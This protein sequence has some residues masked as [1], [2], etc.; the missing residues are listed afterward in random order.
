MVD[1]DILQSSQHTPVFNS[2]STW[3]AGL[4]MIFAICC[5]ELEPIMGH[6]I[7]Y[8]S[9]RDYYFNI[10]PGFFKYFVAPNASSLHDTIGKFLLF[11]VVFD[12][13]LIVVL[14][15]PFAFTAAM[16]TSSSGPLNLN[17]RIALAI[18]TLSPAT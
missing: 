17:S 6:A 12:A 9:I 1:F 7:S 8:S 5:R 14:E 10:N 2:V 13:Y 15:P 3:P 16:S 11:L 18:T 4:L